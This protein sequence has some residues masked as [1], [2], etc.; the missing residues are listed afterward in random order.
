[1]NFDNKQEQKKV[2]EMIF[3]KY[4]S[5]VLNPEQV[6]KLLNI[7]TS[8]L[9]RWRAECKYL[10]YRKIGNSNNSSIEYSIF[11][12]AEYICATEIQII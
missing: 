3:N 11:S 1:M 7:S 2:A 6:A 10:K 9:G 8:T 4:E 5:L 12:I